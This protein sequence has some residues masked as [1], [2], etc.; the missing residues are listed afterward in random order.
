MEDE[1][2]KKKEWL[3]LEQQAVE[4]LERKA[5]LL[6]RTDNTASSSRDKKLETQFLLQYAHDR[7]ECETVATRFVYARY[8]EYAEAAGEKP[9]P[10]A[11]FTNFMLSV[12]GVL[13]STKSK[14]HQPA[15]YLVDWV[16]LSKTLLEAPSGPA[17]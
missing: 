2:Q 5:A 17:A 7:V 16:C 1:L 6:K 11:A 14:K 10:H 4:L 13:R 15:T 12:H 9:L 8:K 3:K